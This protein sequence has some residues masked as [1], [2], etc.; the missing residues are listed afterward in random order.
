MEVEYTVRQVSVP[1]ALREQAEEGM[2]RIARIL[3]KTAR[4]SLTFRAQR[5][6]HIAEL[7]VTAR[8][9][10]IVAAGKA[11]TLESALRKALA[12]AELQAQRYRDRH[13]QRKRLPK[14]EKVLTDP[15]VRRPKTRAAEPELTARNGKTART[16]VT[17]AIP[18]HSFPANAAVMEPH[19]QRSGEAV[20]MKPMSIEEAVKDAEFRDRDLLI[21][22]NPAGEL[23]V[24]HRRK[25]GQMELVEV[26]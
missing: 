21:F 24:L 14:E 2:E 3:G 6:L 22:R 9:Q 4:A 12:H 7:T 23:F 1:K 5:H 20:S 13:Y 26:P 15:P 18:V 10:T 8:Q 25:D 17:T 16:K 11:N 19:V